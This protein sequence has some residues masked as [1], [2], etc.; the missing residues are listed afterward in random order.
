M[1]P[2]SDGFPSGIYDTFIITHT[3]WFTHEDSAT[4]YL[5]HADM[6]FDEKTLI[7]ITNIIM[8]KRLFLSL[9]YLF[10]FTSHTGFT[11]NSLLGFFHLSFTLFCHE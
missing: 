1:T 10:F 4:K 7:C 9:F 2:N 11:L 5:L 6:E 8:R 3:E